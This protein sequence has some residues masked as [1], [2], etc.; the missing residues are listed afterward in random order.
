GE[1]AIPIFFDYNADGLMDIIV[2]NYGIY[3]PS[4]SS[5]FYISSLWLYENMGTV[6]SPYY[7]LITND[8]LNISTM[9]LDIAGCMPTLGVHPTFGDLDNDN[10]LDMILGDY[11]GKIHYFKNSGGAGNPAIFTLSSPNFLG[12]DV[13][14]DA[15]PLLHDLDKD[16]L[17]DLIIGKRTGTFSYYRNTGTA[18]SPSFTFV[19][20][21]LGK[22]ITKRTVDFNGKSNPVIIDS[23]GTTILFSGSKNGYLYK[24]GNIDGNLTGNFSV[25][26][27]YLNIWEGESSNIAVA[28][29]TNDGNLD[30]LIGNYSGGVAFYKGNSIPPPIGID[31]KIIINEFSIYPNPTNGL[32]TINFGNN[33]LKNASIQVID[34]L[35]KTLLNQKITAQKTTLNLTNYAKGIYLV[36][37][38]NEIGSRVYKVVKE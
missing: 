4:L 12:I 16:G 29:I 27:T 23:A 1:G 36:K 38:S 31:E 5:S 37:F 15:A 2:G 21:S 33:K 7:Q 32:I 26:S 18:S 17:I 22:A 3:D 13:G 11:N 8:Y 10:D 19:T 9:N 28:D 25:D 30:M 6:N 14:N 35:G 24:F 20:D 34:L